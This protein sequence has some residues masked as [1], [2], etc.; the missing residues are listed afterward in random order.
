MQGVVFSTFVVVFREALEAALIIGIILT[1]LWKLGARRYARHVW[2]GVAA[3]LVLSLGLGSW[4]SSLADSAQERMGP[5]IEGVI[6][7][8]ACAVLT[9]MFFWIEKQARHLKTDIETRLERAIPAGDRIAIMVLPFFAVLR[10]GAET[11]LFLKAVSMQSGGA[12]SW[13]GGLS[14]LALAVM[15]VLMLFVGGIRV[16][17]QALFRSVGVFI[18]F[19]A[20][21][22]LGY[23]L[24]ELGEVGWVPVGI[25]HLYDINH[26]MN[27]KEGVGSFLKALFGYNGNP[28]L[29]ETVLY[30]LYLAAMFFAMSRLRSAKQK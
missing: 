3:A 22:L 20:A 5:I 21:G 27:E 2:A 8:A 13:A 30:W 14:G 9:Y 11:V 19:I 4:L 18:L 25:E 16:P 28:S 6:S 12:V 17:L 15:V 1:L 26:I 29:T 23:G 7:L 10:E 24:H